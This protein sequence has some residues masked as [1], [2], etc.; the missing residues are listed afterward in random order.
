MMNQCAVSALSAITDTW[1]LAP[2]A[3]EIIWVLSQLQQEDPQFGSPVGLPCCRVT[4]YSIVLSFETPMNCFFFYCCGFLGLNSIWSYS[5]QKSQFLEFTWSLSNCGSWTAGLVVR[6]RLCWPLFLFRVVAI[7]FLYR[8]MVGC[9]V[10]SKS[11]IRIT[12]FI[13]NFFVIVDYVRVSDMFHFKQK[14]KF[15]LPSQK[16]WKWSQTAS[17]S[18]LFP[19]FRF[20][21]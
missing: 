8:R 5:F 9:Y 20:P 7:K 4:L 14:L 10:Q 6:Q 1:L 17:P 15:G 16:I 13:C 3:L 18:R 21:F 19:P 12:P 2:T 11:R